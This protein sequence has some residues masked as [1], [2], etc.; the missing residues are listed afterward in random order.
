MC[1]VCVILKK[2][3]FLEK[4]KIFLENSWTMGKKSSGLIKEAGSV[5]SR[6]SDLI[7]FFN[8]L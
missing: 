6:L 8:L 1:T 4:K 3:E 5:N 2:K 7:D